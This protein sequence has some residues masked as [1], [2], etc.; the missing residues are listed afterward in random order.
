MCRFY[1]KL[2]GPDFENRRR[3]FTPSFLVCSH[4]AVALE[5]L[6]A[7]P[8]LGTALSP[9]LKAA[10]AAEPGSVESIRLHGGALLLVHQHIGPDL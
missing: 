7:D 3:S 10:T 8:K 2:L 4:C 6:P 1:L 9:C 5:R